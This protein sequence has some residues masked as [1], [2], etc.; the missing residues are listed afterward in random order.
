MA[1]VLVVGALVV[2]VVT[3]WVIV[4]APELLAA[5]TRRASAGGVVL[6][7]HG[8]LSQSRPGLE[9]GCEGGGREVWLVGR[10]PAGEP[11]CVVL[12][13]EPTAGDEPMREG[14]V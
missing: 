5:V 8:D 10:G 14:I 6:C 2:L 7:P 9:C 12:P 3:G 4:R 1:P 11:Q 13:Q